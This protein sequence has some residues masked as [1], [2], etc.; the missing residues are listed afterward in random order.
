MWID[1]RRLAFVSK[2]LQGL[3]S[4]NYVSSLEQN[5]LALLEVHVI[6]HEH[7]QAVK[8]APQLDMTLS[9]HYLQLLLSLLEELLFSVFK[10][11][12]S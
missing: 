3:A 12:L 1:R 5:E 10:I 4:E 2:V 6:G 7:V 8:R 11:K 9:Q